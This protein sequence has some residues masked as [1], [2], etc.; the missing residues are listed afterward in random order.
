MLCMGVL[1]GLV[2][3]AVVF[4]A[5]ADIITAGP[6]RVRHLSKLVWVFIVV[7]LPLTGSVLWFVVG[8]SYARPGEIDPHRAEQSPAPPQYETERQLAALERE[9]VASQKDE[10]IRRLE[11]ELRARRGEEPAD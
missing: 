1:L 2:I 9:I 8:R 10:R 6:S 5:L 11:A 4:G 3:F 7:L